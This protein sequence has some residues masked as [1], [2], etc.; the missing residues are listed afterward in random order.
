MI[1]DGR[2]SRTMQMKSRFGCRLAVLAL[3]LAFLLLAVPGVQAERETVDK[4][5][6]V[7][8]DEIIL[9]SELA[10]QIQLAAFQQGE[11]PKT[12]EELKEFQKMVLEQMI[13]DRLFLMEA[14]KDTSI[15]VRP[16][17]VQQALDDQVARVIR[18]F[19]SE[20]QFLQALAMEGMTLRDLER[21]YYED[22]QNNLLRQR[23]IQR[24]LYDVSVS[25]YEVEQF[26][27]EFKD[28]IPKQPEGAKLAHILLDI[29][30]AKEIEDSVYNLGR[31]LRQRILDGADFAAIS[32]EYSSYGAGD[33]GGDLGFMG[34]DDVVPEFARAAFKLGVG[35]VSGV[36]R[37]QFGYHIIKCEGK[38]REKLRLRHVLLGVE[39]G[40]QD[41][42]RTM[43]LADSLLQEIRAGAEFGELAKTF[44]ADDDSR[45]QGGEL[46]WFS[47]EQIPEDFRTSVAG[48]TTP[49]E[50]RGPVESRFGIHILKL[51]DYQ[52][53]KILSL[54]DDYDQIKELARQDKTGKLVDEWIEEIKDRTYID[55]RIEGLTAL[56]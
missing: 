47:I 27:S 22:I 10:S 49:G 28:S 25:R 1:H 33:N 48:W 40:L 9:A 53:E 14:K 34:P 15:E 5:A 6:V 16:D 31:D 38:R 44:S 46:G 2:T 30:P 20:D 26:Y 42:L 4:V 32:A 51:L 39:A 7:V 24:K 11:R 18:N 54:E 36:I 21:Q 17:E 23:Y 35:D 29:K 56:E 19:G 50:V 41:T 52:K 12:E 8:G 13:S 37:T 55:Y 43:A 3:A 45:A